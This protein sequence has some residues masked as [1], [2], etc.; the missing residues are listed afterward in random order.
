MSNTR[1]ITYKTLKD[2][3]QSL[4]TAHK[5][6]NGFYRFDFSEING[7]FRAGIGL[8]ALLLEAPSSQLKSKTK[9]ASNFNERAV[10]FLI[11]DHA[12]AIDNYDKKDDVLTDTEGIALDIQSYLVKCAKDSSHWLF[13]K[14]DINSVRI[15]KVGP[16]FDNYYGWNVLYSITAQETM[17]FDAEKWD[18]Q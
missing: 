14:F 5:E 10:S 4:A 15:E 8:P 3:H 9:M 6:I 7:Q 11:I 2:F 12:G 13:G 18:L 1:P 16:L 17:C